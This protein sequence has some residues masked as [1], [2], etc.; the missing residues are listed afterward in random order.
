[1][2]SAYKFYRFLF[3]SVCIVLLVTVI[4]Y[5]QEVS[6]PQKHL[7]NQFIERQITLGNLSQSYAGVRPLTYSKV[8]DMLKQ[9]SLVSN[10]LSIIEQNLLQRFMI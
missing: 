9:V 3:S 1:M 2:N 10:E 4:S 8:R 6:I 7:V 5:A